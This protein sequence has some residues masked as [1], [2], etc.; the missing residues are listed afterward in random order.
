MAVSSF[1]PTLAA[2]RNSEDCRT[3]QCIWSQRSRKDSPPQQCL[4][5]I[6]DDGKTRKFLQRLNDTG[7]IRGVL[8]DL[9]ALQLCG[10]SHRKKHIGLVI[11]EWIKEIEEE[12]LKPSFPAIATNQLKSSN[13]PVPSP[14]SNRSLASNHHTRS[15]TSTQPNLS[16]PTITPSTI[17]QTLQIDKGDH[18]KC[19]GYTV[20]HNRCTQ[21]LSQ[22][23]CG[24]I[25]NIVESLTSSY[26]VISDKDDITHI[27]A[28]LAGLVMCRGYHKNQA[29]ELSKKWLQKMVD[30]A[31]S[32]EVDGESFGQ[33][34]QTHNP[35]TPNRKRGS[36]FDPVMP[37]TIDDSPE[38]TISSMWSRYPKSRF[39]TPGTSPH[40]S[41]S[42]E[43]QNTSPLSSKAGATYRTESLLGDSDVKH[44]IPD[45]QSH[46]SVVRKLFTQQSSNSRK[47]TL[48]TSRIESPRQTILA[49]VPFP[50]QS[51]EK[52]LE[53]IY[54]VI[55]RPLSEQ[56]RKPG[57]IYGFQRENNGHIK[58]GV[59]KDVEARMRQWANSC[60]YEPKILLKI[61]V[62]H[63]FRVER[64][65]QLHLQNERFRENLVDG[66]CNSG[67]G[68]PS[69]HQE[70]F[71]VGL[72]RVQK[73]IGIWKRFMESEPYDEKY[74]LKSW[75]KQHL[76]K[77][78]L[79]SNFDL[80]LDWL[81]HI[82][83]D[84]SQIVVKRKGENGKLTG[85][86]VEE[87]FEAKNFKGG[88]I[89]KE[90]P[91]IDLELR[92]TEKEQEIKTLGMQ[93]RMS[94]K[95]KQGTMKDN[96]SKGIIGTILDSTLGL[97]G[98]SFVATATV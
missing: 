57:Y 81:G 68:C 19:H 34:E 6:S 86:K 27:L 48:R 17:R 78:H 90:E 47:A 40:Q 45:S 36:R 41:T 70:W 38:S 94:I 1:L 20:R 31:V 22:P 21:P 69:K 64:L 50:I 5:T 30:F 43:L 54:D 82:L 87:K 23:T 52:M 72:E 29:P 53:T 11:D 33:D 51:T 80:W 24:R 13:I 25:D 32:A 10:R 46:T 15:V 97:D 92:E 74:A 61:A 55:S 89:V 60:H 77:I 59:T 49:F 58:I 67:S 98:A 71:K 3:R 63:A 66:L 4:R 79:C 73:V 88:I 35:S 42:R 14:A 2:L 26:S 44:P 91:V 18:L 12:R 16:R 83:D 95:V 96:S 7:D 75:W 56:H 85:V 39:T 62:P 9:A 8:A 76:K 93:Y 37:P 28:E 65:I 84:N